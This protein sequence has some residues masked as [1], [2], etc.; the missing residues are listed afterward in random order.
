MNTVVQYIIVAIIIVAALIYMI[1]GIRRRCKNS[2]G[3]CC[4]CA[5]SDACKSPKNKKTS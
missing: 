5:I 3:S 4:D 1:A 2:G